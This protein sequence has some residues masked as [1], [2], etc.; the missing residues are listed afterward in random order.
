[1]A[2]NKIWS[3]EKKKYIKS[4]IPRKKIL[5]ANI[6]GNTTAQWKDENIDYDIIIGYYRAYDVY[7]A[8]DA[9]YHRG[10]KYASFDC[11]SKYKDSANIRIGYRKRADEPISTE[12]VILIPCRELEEFCRHS[13]YYLNRY[14]TDNE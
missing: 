6:Y 5:F 8:C 11:V 14:D 7:I 13:D 1:M 9:K 3:D 4:L 12:R 10:H 2:A